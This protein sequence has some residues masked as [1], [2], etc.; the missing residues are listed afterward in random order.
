MPHRLSRNRPGRDRAGP[1]GTGAAGARP[2]EGTREASLPATLGVALAGLALFFAVQHART[3]W[4][5]FVLDD[6]IFLDK[7][8]HAPF[9]SLWGFRDLPLHFYRP[10]S[11]E[12][13]FWVLQRLF[14]TWPVPYHVAN[15][16]LWL[17]VLGLY[18]ALVRRLAGPAAAAVAACGVA[19]LSS[20]GVLL[21]WA[22][23]SQDLWM[24]LFALAALLAVAHGRH[25][26]ATVLYAGALLS[27]ET[28]ALLPAIALAQAL[29]LERRALGG[30]LRRVL[31]MGLVTVVWALAHPLLGGRLGHPVPP[32]PAAWTRLPL[33]A[34]ASHT[35][36]SVLNLDAWPRPGLAWSSTLPWVLAGAAPLLLVVAWAAWR[37]CPVRGAARAQE[38][39]LPPGRLALFAAVWMVLGWLPLFAPFVYWHAYY[40]LLGTLGAWLLLA[41]WL[42]RRLALAAVLVVAVVALRVAQLVTPGTGFGTEWFQWRVAVFTEHT[43]QS[44]QRAHPT[45][46]PHTRVYLSNVPGSVGLVPG[47]EESGILRAWYGDPTLQTRFY[48]RY[49]L[50]VPGAPPG[51]DFFF[52]HDSLA[53]WRE[54]VAGPE[55]LTR[56]LAADTVWKLDHNDLAATMANARDWRGAAA[57][58]E[59]LATVATW[60]WDYAYDVGLCR[61]QLGDTA[62]AAEWYRRAAQRPGAAAFVLEAARR[63]RRFLRP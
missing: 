50:R 51:R 52:V 47:A 12:L 10:W 8:R 36:L 2:G 33:P 31:P 39:V 53:G 14:G 41:M 22:S 61:E 27:K 54:V 56:A 25:G 34:A 40:A 37:A 6:F 7:T 58:W 60:R 9:L 19:A 42:R 57:E 13:H 28:A 5:P 43:R 30:A 21:I 15:A 38:S 45:L 62:A 35:L 55:S 18:A 4:A 23:G 3:L 46:P 32:P 29:I 59:K 48:S 11:R 24:L 20:W 49:R 44:L 63:T 26:W 16:V 1:A 17:G